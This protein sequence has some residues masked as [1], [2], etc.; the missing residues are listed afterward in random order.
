MHA[1]SASHKIGVGTVRVGASART[2]RVAEA[3]PSAYIRSCA[4]A[5]RTLRV[6]EAR[7]SACIGSR[8]SSVGHAVLVPTA[9]S[10][11]IA[12]RAEVDYFVPDANST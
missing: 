6:V 4:A 7:P 5:A 2:P 3:R 1:A 11:F 12:R 8:G 9:F 10:R